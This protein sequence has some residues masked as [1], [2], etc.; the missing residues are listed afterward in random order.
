MKWLA[1]A[2]SLTTAGYT[3]APEAK[4]SD[5]GRW[6]LTGTRVYVGPDV[7]PL[8]NAWVLVEGGKIK[9]VGDASAVKPA[10]IQTNAA[11]SGGVI[12]AGFQNSHVHFM[13]PAY[14]DAS[15]RPSA[16][17]ERPLSQMLTG[18]GYTTVVDTGSDI[19]VTAALR[20]RIDSGDTKGP[21]ILTAGVPIYPKNGL[22]FYLRDLPP[23]V[24]Q[25]LAQPATPDEAVAHVRD[26]AH[27][28]RDCSCRGSRSTPAG[29]PGHGSSN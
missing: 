9:A 20:Q 4:S 1:L 10:N 22:P 18:F 14:V 12:T 26:Q 28:R 8:D 2:L 17:L 15:K 29:P 25:M 16:E 21:A 7:A 23:E 13:D 11:C 24:L 5:E 19:T 27:V 3:P 6:L